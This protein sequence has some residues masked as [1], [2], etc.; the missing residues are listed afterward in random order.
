MDRNTIAGLLLIFIILIGYSIWQQPS[1]EDLIRQQQIRDSLER[2]ERERTEVLEQRAQE[3][4]E[5]NKAK[6]ETQASTDNS[7]QENEVLDES[8]LG[9]FATA[10][11]GTDKEYTILTDLMDIKVSSKGGRI[12]KV[13]LN[14]YQTYDSLPLV[15]FTKDSSR[16][17]FTFFSNNRT[18]N[19]KDLYFQPVWLSGEPTYNDRIELSGSDSISFAMRMYPQG[20]D[21]DDDSYIDYIY[22]IH[23]DQY[24]LDFDV[25]FVNMNEYIANNVS[26]LNLDWYAQLNRHDKPLRNVGNGASVYYMFTD[27]DVEN[28]SETDDLAEETISTK[29]K[30]VAFK[31]RFFSSVLIADNAFDNAELLSEDEIPDV[32]DATKRGH[33]LRT[34]QAQFGVPYTPSEK[35]EIPMRFYFGPNKYNILKK[36][37]IGLEELIPLGWGIL[38]WINRFAVI[39]VFNFLEGFNI[40]YGIIILI[41]TLLLKLVLFPIAYKTYKSQAKM[42]VL[43]PEIDELGKKFPKKEDAMKKQ[44]ATMSLYKKAGVNPAAGCVPMLLQLPILIAMFRFFPASIELRQQSF[45]W[46]TDLS[47]YDS[48]FSLPFSIPFYGDHV[49]LFTLLMTAS[50]ILYTKMNSE[51]MG[52]SS[53]QMPGMKT[54]MYFMPVMLLFFLNNYASALSYYYLLANLITFGQMF[55]IKR[56]IDEDKIRRQIAQNKKKPVKKSKWQ[57][58][59][60]KMAREQKKARK[61]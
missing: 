60:E 46:T 51:M 47:S 16:F 15:L 22:T 6:K 32:E 28:L 48:I 53:Q 14:N 27:D 8:V 31:Q 34:M 23:G 9:P 13:R 43:K 59:M 1:Q 61:K 10:S 50:T 33:Y 39:P 35:V 25:E 45:L 17:N 7:S 3:R 19:T 54:M 55:L 36:H 49:S 26:Y 30:W 21:K 41:L 52:S 12:S 29:L 11:R 24:M 5:E 44:Q 4:Q 58:R 38:S 42:R 18:I 57:D 40:N 20:K 37:D 56:S 2:V